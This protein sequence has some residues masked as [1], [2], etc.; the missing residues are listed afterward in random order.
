MFRPG[1]TVYTSCLPCLSCS[2]VY[3]VGL[4]SLPPA[5]RSPSPCPASVPGTPGHHSPARLSP[6]R[7]PCTFWG[8]TSTVLSKPT[9]TWVFITG[10]RAPA[11][12]RCTLIRC[13]AL[14]GARL[15]CYDQPRDSSQDQQ[16]RPLTQR[17][18]RISQQASTQTALPADAPIATEIAAALYHDGPAPALPYNPPKVPKSHLSGPR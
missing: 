14:P 16:C 3:G 7:S 5:Y 6:D 1:H 4:P 2:P 9:S 12:S 8:P 17:Y 10:C 11:P 18:I 15:V 13:P